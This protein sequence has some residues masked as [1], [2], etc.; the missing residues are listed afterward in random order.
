MS[1]DN[2]E[3]LDAP[4]NASLVRAM[5][6]ALSIFATLLARKGLIETDEVANILGMYAVTT[7]EVDQEEGLILGSWAAM[8][9]DLAD[10]QDMAPSA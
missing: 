8:L 7:G 9:R 1:N 3:S 6:G 5:G 2:R 4:E 10:L